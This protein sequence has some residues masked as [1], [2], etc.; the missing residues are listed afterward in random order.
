M[1]FSPRRKSFLCFSAASL[2]MTAHG[3]TPEQ[4]ELRAV[5]FKMPL[6]VRFLFA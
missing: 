5:V 1:G 4:G 2:G 3:G 6:D